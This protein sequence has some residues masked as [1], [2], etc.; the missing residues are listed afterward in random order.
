[1]QTSASRLSSARRS[2]V[3]VA[4][5]SASPERSTASATHRQPVSHSAAARPSATQACWQRGEKGAPVRFRRKGAP[6]GQRREEP[7]QDRLMH[8]IDRQAVPAG[9]AYR[10]RRRRAG[11][12]ALGRGQPLYNPREARGAEAEEDDACPGQKR[13][14]VERVRQRLAEPEPQ[15]P[16]RI[17]HGRAYEPRRRDRREADRKTGSRLA[18]RRTARR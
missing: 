14:P 5:R 15:E 11:K 17:E 7:D 16:G 3:T 18:P 8:E 2:G 12:P 6:G 10:P 4:S 1:M 9:E 13:A